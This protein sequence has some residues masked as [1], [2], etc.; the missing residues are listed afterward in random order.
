MIGAEIPYATSSVMMKRMLGFLCWA[1]A[2]SA[3]RARTVVS[4]SST[5]TR[6]VL[7]SAIKFVSPFEQILHP[8]KPSEQQ[9]VLQLFDQHAF[10]AH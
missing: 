8:H 4:A 7:L 3:A 1:D 10:A 9:V 2:G 5:V 6:N